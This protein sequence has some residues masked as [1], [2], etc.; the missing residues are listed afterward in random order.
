VISRSTSHCCFED[1]VDL[2]LG[3]ITYQTEFVAEGILHHGPVDDRRFVPRRTGILAAQI[4]EASMPPIPGAD[5]LQAS[6]FRP[7]PIANGQV[8]YIEN[9]A[10]VPMP[11][12]GS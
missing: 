11:M 9:R 8:V 2:R 5:H 10:S 12:L 1:C 6:G 4:A 7:E 3:Q